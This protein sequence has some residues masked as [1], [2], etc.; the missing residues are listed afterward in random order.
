[1]GRVLVVMIA[2]SLGACAGVRGPAP[3]RNVPFE[4]P[5]P[6]ERCALMQAVRI[7]AEQ[8]GL[9]IAAEDVAG[10]RITAYTKVDG[11]SREMWR[12]KIKDG[13]VAVQTYTETRDGSAWRISPYLP[14][15]Y[16]Y[17]RERR[18]LAT[19]AAALGVSMIP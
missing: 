9:E 18:Q 11:G 13:W 3:R 19:I 6:A 7:V 15:S 12:Y 8:Q 10:G 1:M 16:E 2:L 4:R 14:A 5:I 17:V